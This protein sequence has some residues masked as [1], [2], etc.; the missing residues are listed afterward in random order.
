MLWPGGVVPFLEL[1]PDIS[2]QLLE[3]YRQFSENVFIHGKQQSVIVNTFLV[4]RSKQACLAT[5]I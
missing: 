1:P 3:Y 4:I 2:V 5:L